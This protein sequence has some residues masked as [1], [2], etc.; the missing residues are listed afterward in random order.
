MISCHGWGGLGL[1]GE[2]GGGGEQGGGGTRY[3]WWGG[4]GGVGCLG[5][6]YWGS[7]GWEGSWVALGR[8]VRKECL[9]VGS[10]YASLG[11]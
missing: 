8:G 6:H 7:F 2:D 11:Y 1:R 9:L 10:L 5:V 3:G 4:C